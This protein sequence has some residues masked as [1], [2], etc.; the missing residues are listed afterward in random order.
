M[1]KSRFVLKWVFVFTVLSLWTFVVVKGL[2]LSTTISSQVVAPESVTGIVM[3]SKGFNVP[4]YIIRD[5]GKV[6]ARSSDLFDILFNRDFEAEKVV[7]VIPMDK[8]S[9]RASGGNA[10]VDGNDFGDNNKLNFNVNY[11][12][13]GKGSLVMKDG[14]DRLSLSFEPKKIIETN[15]ERLVFESSGTGKLNRESFSESSIIIEFD[16]NLSLLNIRG[17]LGR[18]FTIINM[19]A[20]VLKGCLSEE[21]TFFL[22][23]DNGELDESRSINEVRQILNDNPEYTDAY[24]NLERL[25]KDKWWL[26]VP[27]GIVS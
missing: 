3:P 8:C 13:N 7:E 2:I 1:G 23:I 18:N 9:M 14:S 16:K 20:D 19:E 26:I 6:K 11:L 4:F 21:T 24:Q 22:I 10:E 17:G 15:T 12:T 25:F 27:S 5:E